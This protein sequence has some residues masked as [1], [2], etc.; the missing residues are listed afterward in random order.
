[1]QRKVRDLAL[2][3]L[4]IDSKLRG[5]DLVSLKVE[6]IAP[7]PSSPPPFGKRKQG[8]NCRSSQT[9]GTAGSRT[10]KDGSFDEEDDIFAETAAEAETR[11]ERFAMIEEL[12]SQPQLGTA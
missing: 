4:A 8:G 9:H 6:D 5:C 2:F 3:N 12:L 1:M 11:R 10:G 7:T